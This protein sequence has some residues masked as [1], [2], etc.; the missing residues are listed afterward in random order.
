MFF[1]ET[2]INTSLINVSN[3]KH[4]PLYKAK[5]RSEDG[6]HAVTS[7]FIAALNVPAA[8]SPNLTSISINVSAESSELLCCNSHKDGILRLPR[9]LRVAMTLPRDKYGANPAVAALTALCALG[10]TLATARINGRKQS[11]TVVALGVQPLGVLRG[12]QTNSTASC[13][14][15]S[16]GVGVGC[17]GSEM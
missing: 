8:V 17:G 6:L 2:F 3:G 1:L 14:Q 5:N 12:L 13:G 7:I 15:M 16:G 11:V 9:S 4:M 10:L